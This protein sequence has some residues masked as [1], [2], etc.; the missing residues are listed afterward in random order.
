MFEVKLLPVS[1]ELFQELL[2]SQL[3]RGR[4]Y[5]GV[6]NKGD[7]TD[8]FVLFQYEEVSQEEYERALSKPGVKDIYSLVTEAQK[9]SYKTLTEALDDLTILLNRQQSDLSPST[10]TEHQQESSFATHLKFLVGDSVSECAEKLSI[11]TDHLLRMIR[12]EEQPS[13]EF[14]SFIEKTCRAQPGF[15][16]GFL[17]DFLGQD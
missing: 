4:K 2:N 14:A 15:L 13:R 9:G 10:N 5:C 11:S 1:P 12:G 16:T 17:T 6:V 7:S 3:Q 8:Q